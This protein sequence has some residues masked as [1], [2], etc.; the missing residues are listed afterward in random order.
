MDKKQRS[1][2]KAIMSEDTE[3]LHNI[4]SSEGDFV[5]GK[6]KLV[7]VHTP[8]SFA[9]ISGKE[10]VINKLVEDGADVNAK[11][12]LGQVPLHIACNMNHE[13]M[14]TS[15]LNNGADVNATDNNGNNALF[16]L[17]NYAN[18]ND[19]DNNE[20]AKTDIVNT[21]QILI[22]KGINLH[23]KNKKGVNISNVISKLYSAKKK[24]TN[25][26]KKSIELIKKNIDIKE[27][28]EESNSKRKIN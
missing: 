21:L 13:I 2:I 9:V 6:I 22:N 28:K 19:L 23:H 11:L 15:L 25:N 4:F 1:I 27:K 17:L 8:L 16:Y 7:T 12:S 14:V 24:L 3:S 20:N 5:N 10:K 18:I 26:E